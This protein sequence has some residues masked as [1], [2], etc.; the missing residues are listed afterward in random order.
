MDPLR[1]RL[2]MDQEPC[3]QPHSLMST[4]VRCKSIIIFLD[5]PFFG[6]STKSLG[7][8][9]WGYGN[10]SNH[11]SGTFCRNE[12]CSASLI[13]SAPGG[14]TGAAEWQAWQPQGCRY[15]EVT[16]AAGFFQFT[17]KC[18]VGVFS[19]MSFG[20]TQPVLLKQCF[21]GP[22]LRGINCSPSLWP[23]EAGRRRRNR[24]RQLDERREEENPSKDESYVMAFVAVW[25]CPLT[26]KRTNWYYKS[27]QRVVFQKVDLFGYCSSHY[28]A[29]ISRGFCNRCLG[30]KD[31]RR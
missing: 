5:S 12:K 29:S 18:L 17:K 2:G 21:A 6:E 4:F 23:R 31:L 13:A 7:F 28:Q 15:P 25:S 9:D 10:Q 11:L 30:L 19:E 22:L 1:P 8:R 14:Q 24:Q 20:F 3:S 16:G 26:Q 27:I